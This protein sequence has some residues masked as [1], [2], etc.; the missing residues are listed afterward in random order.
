MATSSLIVTGADAAYFDLLRDCVMSLRRHQAGRE[1]A[2]AV[3][4]CGLH[5]AQRQWLADRGAQLATPSWDYAASL[6]ERLPPHAKALT[7][8][9]FLPRYFPQAETILWI[10]ADCWI[11]DYAA[12][13]LLQ[14]A[15][16]DGSLAVV[17]EIDRAFRHYRHARDEFVDVVGS[18]Y[19]AAYGQEVASEL[20]RWPM[21]NAGVFAMRRDSK[22]WALWART[23]EAGLRHSADLIDQ[24]ALNV[25][26]YQRGLRHHPLPAWCN[27]PAHHATP[28]WDIER[29]LFVEPW[30]P[31]RPIGI[32]HLTVWTKHEAFQEVRQIGGPAD[33]HLRQM[34]LRLPHG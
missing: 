29:K 17:P 24:L 1:Q 30:L 34:S 2:L 9:P 22:G 26:V 19:R 14:A 21:L 10:D 4:D 12:I 25:A 15:A 23:L 5:E 20:T 8:R 11:Q 3:F 33:G 32:L 18:A 13:D 27:W 31:H 7:A 16:A 6:V 28:A